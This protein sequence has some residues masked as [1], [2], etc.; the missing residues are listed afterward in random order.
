MNL[1][2]IGLLLDFLGG[3]VLF[4]IS[5]RTRGATTPADEDHIISREYHWLGYALL[6]A[7]FLLQIIGSSIGDP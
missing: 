2:N 1:N 3:V 7:G 6:S 4:W 5:T